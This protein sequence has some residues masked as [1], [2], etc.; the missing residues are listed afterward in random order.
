[1][2]LIGYMRVSKNDGSQ[3]LDLQ[4]DA[5]LAA[6]VAPERLYE[7]HAF[8]SPGRA[9]RAHRVPESPPTGQYA[10]GVATRSAR[11]HADPPHL[12]GRGLESAA[13]RVQS[14]GGGGRSDRYH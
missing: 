4:R 9:A 14:P 7:D 12:C 6:G 13:R 5:L 8:G 3:S 2:M 10:R 1:M 11:T